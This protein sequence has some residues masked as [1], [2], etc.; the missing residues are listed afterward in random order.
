[1]DSAVMDRPPAVADETMGWEDNPLLD[2]TTPQEKFANLRREMRASLVEREPEIDILLLAL[3]SGEHAVFCG[4]PGTAKSL[5]CNSLVSGIEN[6]NEFTTLM[7]K[8]TEPSEIFGPLNLPGMKEGRYERLTASYFPDANFVFL[9]EVFKASSAIL[10][11]CLTAMQERK[12][13]NDGKW[14]SIPLM[15]LV[16]SSNEW[17]VGE[18]Y[19][20]LGALFDRFLFRS[21]VKPVSPAGHEK[22]LFSDLPTVNS[23]L[24][25]SDI[26]Q[27]RQEAAVIRVPN[28]TKDAYYTILAELQGNGIKPGDRRCRKAVGAARASAW[29]N[30]HN[31]VRPIDLECLKDVLWEDPREQ[32]LKSAEIICKIANPSGAEIQGILVTAEEIMSSPYMAAF[33]GNGVMSNEAMGGIRKLR[34]TVD[35]LRKLRAGSSCPE[36]VDEAVA[37]L[38][39]R[40]QPML[41]KATNI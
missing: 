23:Q 12:F 8:F 26:K 17:P 33:M 32:P 4:P 16:G 30:G 3:V 2:S 27:A 37:Y 38:K 15:T 20:E 39:G 9:D 5:L 36:R 24:A 31:E 1:M 29:L 13:R 34:D 6:A 21:A 10:N 19:Q 28:D 18:G 11:A 40:M 35:T 14:V 22:L 25:I 7:T 41:M